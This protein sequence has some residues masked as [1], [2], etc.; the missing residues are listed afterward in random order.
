MQVPVRFDSSP[1]VKTF[2]TRIVEGAAG[3][4]NFAGHYLIVEWGCGTSCMSGVVINAMDGRVNF[5][6]TAVWAREY[7]AESIL[8]ANN[9][10]SPSE[11]ENAARP[12][13]AKPEYFLWKDEVFSPIT[14]P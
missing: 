3:D 9:P 6:P 12:E 14:N 8:L 5:L 2:R 10:P 11:Q 1:G 13:W 4:V 7:H